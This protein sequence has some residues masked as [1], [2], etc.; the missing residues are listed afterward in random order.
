MKRGYLLIAAIV[1]LTIC[2]VFVFAACNDENMEVHE[3]TL[4]IQDFEYN[5]EVAKAI[6]DSGKDA[7]EVEWFSVS[8][9]GEL[10]KIESAPKEPG[11][12][13]VR[14]YIPGTDS[15]A[16]V[17]FTISE[18]TTL[19]ENIVMPDKDYDGTPIAAP[20]F[21]TNSDSQEILVRYKKDVDGSEWT[22]ELP[23]E[24]GAYDLSIE[25]AEN[26]HYGYGSATASFFINPAPSLME[27]TVNPSIGLL[28]AYDDTVVGL[29][30]DD[31]DGDLIMDALDVDALIGKDIKDVTKAI[32]EAFNNAGYLAGNNNIII[33][34]QT[35]S[36]KNLAETGALEALTAL[37]LT[38]QVR[39]F[40][41]QKEDLVE[42]ANGCAPELTA[43][44]LA[45]MSEMDLQVFIAK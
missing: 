11:T 44:E 38:N 14:A 34:A 20:T 4:A 16:S 9:S 36:S 13:K 43:E 2:S 27:I 18:A 29:S 45:A 12:Y 30:A 5:G 1:I 31:A 17:G 37:N 39:T 8:E 25:V 10:T 28:V 35:A 22:T 3:L 19:V 32:I 7:V 33:A 26:S 40:D 41:I 15:E 42:L 6:I 24:V 21:T 23:S